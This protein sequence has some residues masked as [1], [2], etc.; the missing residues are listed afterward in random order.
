MWLAKGKRTHGWPQQWRDAYSTVQAFQLPSYIIDGRHCIRPQA[1]DMLLDDDGV[2]QLAP[3]LSP[4]LPLHIEDNEVTKHMS[5]ESRLATTIQLMVTV[6]AAK[7][8]QG[9][10][11]IVFEDVHWMDSSSWALLRALQKVVQPL[12]VLLTLRPLTE[13]ARPA[14]YIEMAKDPSSNVL[15]LEGLSEEESRGLLC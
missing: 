13:V 14:E 9:R 8:R 4:V 11:V 2:V 10:T 12:L 3:L 6:L 5:G 7:L 1:T 15:E